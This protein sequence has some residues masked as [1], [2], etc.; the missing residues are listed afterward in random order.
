MY[1]V[2]EHTADLG[3]RITAPDLPSL[4]VES[5]RGL[6]SLLV[7][8]LESVIPRTETR[9][10]LQGSDRT[11]LFFDWLHEILYRFETEHVLFSEFEVTLHAD[12]LEALARGE[13]IDRMRHQLGHEVKAITYHALKIE[14]TENGYLAEVIVDI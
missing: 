13:P 14:V 6:G 10:S 9:I 8:K 1:E 11:Y 12:G 2:F 7:E 5:A 3:L 4:F